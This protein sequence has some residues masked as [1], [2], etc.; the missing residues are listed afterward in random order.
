MQGKGK[1]RSN[2]AQLTVNVKQS[3]KDGFEAWSKTTGRSTDKLLTLA[4]NDW[5]D[6][7]GVGRLAGALVKQ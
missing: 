5:W 2:P 1:K 4:L 3:T 7:F 6:T